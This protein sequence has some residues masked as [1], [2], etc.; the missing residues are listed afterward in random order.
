MCSGQSE[1]VR[2]EKRLCE[3]GGT[4]GRTMSRLPKGATR[5][6]AHDLLE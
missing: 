5:E 4:E 6:V 3:A 1:K 2:L